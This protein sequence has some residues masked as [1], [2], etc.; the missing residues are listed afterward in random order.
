MNTCF[1]SLI[2]VFQFY[3]FF[4]N[5]VNLFNFCS[6]SQWTGHLFKTSK[7]VTCKT[8]GCRRKENINDQG[9]CIPCKQNETKLEKQKCGTCK[10][11]L[12]DEQKAIGCDK[13]LI[14]HHIECENMSENLYDMIAET[15]EDDGIRWY[16]KTCKKDEISADDNVDHNIQDVNTR[17]VNDNYN[18]DTRPTWKAYKRGKCP[19]G[20]SGKTKVDN[21]ECLHRHPK[22]CIPYCRFGSDR[23]MGCN[24]VDC[25]LMHPILCRFSVGRGLCINEKC[26]FAHLKGTRRKNPLQFENRKMV[27]AN[28]P[29]NSGFMESGQ[30]R[31]DYYQKL[32]VSNRQRQ[33]TG[34]LYNQEYSE[35]L[36]I[37][38]SRQQ[39]RKKKHPKHSKCFS[40]L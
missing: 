12:T 23:A 10:K 26:T 40:S 32:N 13:C 15:E 4:V 17:K 35:Y 25:K 19:H 31:S 6:D 9:L 5:F 11:D 22:K 14:W 16:C 27:N 1:G 37:E 2:S 3:S 18:Q 28:H 33:N 7:M 21:K 20:L 8:K 34:T 30:R 24:K 38:L 39:Q 36:P 29:F